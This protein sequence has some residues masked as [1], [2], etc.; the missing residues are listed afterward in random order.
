MGAVQAPRSGHVIR[1]YT[2]EVSRGWKGR[3][4]LQRGSLYKAFG[5]KQNL[6]QKALAGALAPGWRTPAASIDLLIIDLKELA[7]ADG[8]ITALCRA[9]VLES[10]QHTAS[11]LGAR[12]LQHL[13]DK[14]NDHADA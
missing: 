1:R 12:L 6:F 5:S 2:H 11:I 13:D 10:D 8:A 7:P 4:L 3:L 9:A 14:G